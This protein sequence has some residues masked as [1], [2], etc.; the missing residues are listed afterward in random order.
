MRY[1]LQKDA[2]LALTVFTEE[3]EMAAGTL[4]KRAETFFGSMP[5]V[6]NSSYIS[7]REGL[8][9]WP[10]MMKGNSRSEVIVPAP[11]SILMQAIAAGVGSLTDD[12][13]CTCG[14]RA[15]SSITRLLLYLLKEN[16]VGLVTM[17]G[18]STRVVYLRI[19]AAGRSMAGVIPPRILPHWVRAG[20]PNAKNRTGSSLL[21]AGSEPANPGLG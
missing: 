14:N 18:V 3:L 2:R 7:T 15:F 17:I 10:S 6:P 11:L 20:G 21:K 19:H 5:G 16:R 12:R 4:Q 9:R 13:V 1:E 8:Q